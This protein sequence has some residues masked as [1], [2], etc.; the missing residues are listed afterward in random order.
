MVTVSVKHSPLDSPHSHKDNLILTTKAVTV[1]VQGKLQE[2]KS[3]YNAKMAAVVVVAVVGRGAVG[4]ASQKS[5]AAVQA[6]IV[7]NQRKKGR[8]KNTLK[9]RSTYLLANLRQVLKMYPPMHPT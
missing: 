2:R 4:K 3:A 5:T 6:V 7:I 8:R 9:T 1:H